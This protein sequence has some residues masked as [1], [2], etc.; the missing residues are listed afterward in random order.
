VVFYGRNDV[1]ETCRRRDPV[2]RW[3]DGTPLPVLGAS[4]VFFVGA[5]YLVLTGLTIPLFPFFGRYL[6]GVAGSMCLIVLAAID[7]YLAIAIFRLKISGWWLAV[8]VLPIRLASVALTYARGDMMQAYAKIGMSDAQLKAINSSPIFRGHV[9]LWW[10]LISMLLFFGYI[11]WLK[12][13][14]KAPTVVQPAALAA[15]LI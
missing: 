13:Y 1:A 7:A 11:V 2:E 4:V 3:T 9:L 8:L 15:P 10:G 14:F 12:R 5:L 6:T